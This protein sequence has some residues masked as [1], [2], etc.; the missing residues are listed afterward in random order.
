MALDA[1]INI[2][3]GGKDFEGS[4]KKVGHPKNSSILHAVYHSLDTPVDLAAGAVTHRR[5]HGLLVVE[6]LIDPSAYQIY[7][8]CIT[9]D[10]DG[11]QKLDVAIQFYRT[12]QDNIGLWGGGENAPFYKITL[13]EAF[14]AGVEFVMGDA[15]ATAGIAGAASAGRGEFLRVKFAYRAIEWMFMQGNKAAQDSWSAK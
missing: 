11:S 1:A 15:R 4:S 12:N 3:Q 13:T 2:K 6:M 9:K 7:N 10:Q 5:Q 14:I 8:A